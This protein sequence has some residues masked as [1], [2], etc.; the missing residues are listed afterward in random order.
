MQ[1]AQQS[2]QTVSVEEPNAIEQQEAAPEIDANS[3]NNQKQ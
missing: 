2:D 3:D 1:K